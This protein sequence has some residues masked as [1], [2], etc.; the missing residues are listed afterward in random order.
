M[1]VL[2]EE[3]V[4]RV[5]GYLKESRTESSQCMGSSVTPRLGPDPRGGPCI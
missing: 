4:R 2:M 3:S 1:T 5:G